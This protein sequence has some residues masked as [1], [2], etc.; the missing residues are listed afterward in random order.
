[1][2]ND[3]MIAVAILAQQAA[4]ANQRFSDGKGLCRPAAKFDHCYRHQSRARLT[5]ASRHVSTDC[6]FTHSSV[7]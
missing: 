7:L 2:Q 1:M 3:D 5:N 4:T 6:T